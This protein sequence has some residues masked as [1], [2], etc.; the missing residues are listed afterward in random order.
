MPWMPKHK[1]KIKE[2]ITKSSWSSSKVVGLGPADLWEFRTLISRMVS[3]MSCV[4]WIFQ[5]SK[6]T[7]QW[8]YNERGSV[9]NHHPHDCFLNRLFMCRSTKT[10]KL[11][12]IGLCVGSSSMTGEFPA[13]RASN[14]EI[15]SIWWRHHEH[16]YIATYI[17][18]FWGSVIYNV[19]TAIYVIKNDTWYFKF[20]I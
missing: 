3:I 15:V 14:G 7:L 13:Q 19:Q 17:C 6:E 10:S 20:K 16:V 2:K 1:H 18:T 11:R 5:E 9:S 8:R 12:V 4:S